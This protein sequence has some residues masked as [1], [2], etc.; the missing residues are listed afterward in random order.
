MEKP[1]VLRIE[2]LKTDFPVPQPFSLR[3][4]LSGRTSAR[5]DGGPLLRRVDL[6]LA[7]GEVLALLGEKGA[8]KTTLLRAAAGLLPPDGGC[9]ETAGCRSVLIPWGAA[10]QGDLTV[11]ENIRL[12]LLL[13]GFPSAGTDEK[14]QEILAFSE[15]EAWAD[16]RLYEC[17]GELW[18]RLS[19]AVTALAEA[20][21]F[22]VDELPDMGS[23]A[24]RKKAAGKLRELLSREERTAIVA[25]ADA[26][27]IESFADRAVWL[28]GGRIQ[29]SGPAEQ[30]A[31]LYRRWYRVSCAERPVLQ[32]RGLPEG[33]GHIPLYRGLE[34]DGELGL[35]RNAP[36]EQACR[37]AACWEPLP[38]HRGECLKLKRED[39]EYRAFVYREGRQ[40]EW[41]CTSALQPEGNWTVYSREASGLTWRQD[42][43]RIMEE[44]GFLRLQVRRRDGGMLPDTLCLED[45]F[46]LEDAPAGELQEVRFDEV[47]GRELADTAEEVRRARR[48]GDAVVLLLADTHTVFGGTWEDTA[49]V[50]SR[51]T[52]ALSIGEIVHLGDLTDGLCPAAETEKLIRRIRADLE[53]TGA[54]VHICPGNHDLLRLPGQKAPWDARG[55]A[56]RFLGQELPYGYE[57]LPGEGLRLVFLSS[58][59][60]EEA[61]PYGFPEEE[62][63]WLERTLEETPEDRA[64]LVFSHIRPGPERTR[65][66]DL[67]RRSRQ[68]ME[69]LTRFDQ[70]RGGAVLGVF[71]GHDHRDYISG[72]AAFPVIGIGCAKLEDKQNSPLH[73]GRRTRMEGTASQELLDILVVHKNEKKM[74]L[75]RFG[76][77]ENRQAAH[78]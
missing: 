67:I 64:V 72:E 21:I 2:N 39:M 54:G 7:Q 25:S 40:E 60:P 63:E 53:E 69:I 30:V 76:A 32:E 75:I 27:G 15:M 48:P 73:K 8:G 12:A 59:D 17:S 14:R 70:R 78:R 33:K 52:A 77:G 10:F 44:D 6:E 29:A 47:F 74:D 13:L 41:I 71:C 68:V 4:L 24:F 62:T 51:L 22:L 43:V 26:E 38:L 31:A 28:L 56:K 49:R 35:L 57:D 55:F 1:V 19:F 50:I 16:R 3:R 58:Y 37:T 65:W 45:V 42:P 23:E 11:R 66:N 18:S 20:E 46:D 9:V 5:G 61:C 36:E 34:I